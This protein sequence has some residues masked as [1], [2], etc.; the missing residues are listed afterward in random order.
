MKKILSLAAAAL[1]MVSCNG[2]AN[3][4]VTLSDSISDLMGEMYGYGVAGQMKNSPDSAKFDKNAFIQGME[5]IANLDT[6]DMS[7]LQGVQMGMQVLQMQMQLKQQQNVDFDKQ[8]FIAAFKKA[9]SADSL[10]DPQIMQMQIMPLI[11]RASREAKL[12]D[13]IAKKN[14]ADGEAYAAKM[15]KEGYTKTASGLV[16]KMISEGAGETFAADQTIDIKYEGKLIDGKVFDATQGDE[17][18]AMSPNQVVP[19]FKEALMLMKPGAKMIAVL[20][21]DLAYGADGRGDII[22]PNATLVFTIEAVG[23]HADK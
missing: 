4:N 22:G 10:K 9:F 5:L 14:K 2:N 3:K 1:M 15:V 20:P 16:Y 17:T 18:R 11:E 19:G 8:K 21:A 23:I 6:A 12:N 7:K 13:P